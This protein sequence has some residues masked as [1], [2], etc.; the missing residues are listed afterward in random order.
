M[1]PLLIAITAITLVACAT[2][3]V[4][5]NS[6]GFARALELINADLGDPA[7]Q[8]GG[9]YT[10]ENAGACK[11]TYKSTWTQATSTAKGFVAVETTTLVDF[12]ADVQRAVHVEAHVDIKA[13]HIER[14]DESIRI[15]LT[16]PLPGVFKSMPIGE[17]QMS[18][19]TYTVDFLSV[20]V[21]STSTAEQIARLIH[22]VESAVALCQQT[23]T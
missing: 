1:K 10:F 2:S 21:A 22:D 16:K 3:P 7:F 19:R 17:T 8:S 20:G 14:W 5:E 23:A 12:S 13:D 9:V 6:G 18:G 11:A 4:A 15:L